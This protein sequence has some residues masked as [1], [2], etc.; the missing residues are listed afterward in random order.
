MEAACELDQAALTAPVSAGT[1]VG[2]LVCYAGGEELA[3][4]PLI[5]GRDV[6]QD[7]E[8]PSGW[9]SGIWDRISGL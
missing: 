1:Q 6:P 3:R 9:L 5:A 8:E 4:A 7:L 2:E